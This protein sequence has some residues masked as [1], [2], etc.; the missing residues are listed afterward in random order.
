ML[1]PST[2]AINGFTRLAQLGA[3][4]ADV[5]TEF[6]TLWGLALFYG[7]VV[8]MLEFRKQRRDGQLPATDVFCG[9]S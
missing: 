4:L 7:A 6:L 5:R 9:A 3:P 8:W 2:S 1:V